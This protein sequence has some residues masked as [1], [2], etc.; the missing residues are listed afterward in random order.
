MQKQISAIISLKDRFSGPLI[1]M[2]SNVEKI[3]NETRSSMNQ[4]N[5]WGLQVEKSVDRALKSTAKWAK[6]GALVTGAW[7]LKSGIEGMTELDDAARKVKSIS[8]HRLPLHGIKED[9]KSMSFEFGKSYEEIGDGFYNAIS[10]SIPMDLLNE[11]VELAN[12]LSIAGFTDI[13]SSVNLMASTMNAFNMKSSEE[14]QNMADQFLLT[15]NLGVITVDEMAEYYGRISTLSAQIG[16]SLEEQNAAIATMT[17]RGMTQ[18]ESVTAYRSVLNAFLKKSSDSQIAVLEGMGLGS[19]FL[20]AKNYEKLGFDGVIDAVGKAT[21]GD[22]DKISEIFPDIRGKL[23][24]IMFSPDAGMDDFRRILKELGDPEGT[25]D[26]AHAVMNQSISRQ[27]EIFKGRV[28]GLNNEL[29]TEKDGIGGLLVEKLRDANDWLDK[30]KDKIIEKMNE[31]SE[32]I[33]KFIEGTANAITNNRTELLFLVGFLTTI[34]ATLKLFRGLGQFS[35]NLNAIK[36]AIDGL[37]LGQLAA[38]IPFALF[39]KVVV[40]ILAIA[41]SIKYIYDNWD[42][43]IEQY[44]YV[45]EIF[46]KIRE[47]FEELSPI[48]FGIG[49]LIGWAFGLFFSAIE[50]TPQMLSEM[51]F[52]IIELVGGAFQTILGIIVTIMGI[53]VLVFT[54]DA[55]IMEIGFSMVTDGMIGAWTGFTDIFSAPVEAVLDLMESKFKDGVDNLKGWWKDFKEFF[56]KPISTTV[57]VFRKV[58]NTDKDRIL[59]DGVITGHVDPGRNYKGTPNWK[60]GPTWIHERGGEIMDLPGGTRIYPHDESVKMARNEG[61]S[62]AGSS[63]QNISINLGGVNFSGDFN[64]EMDINEVGTKI[65][66]VIKKEL[67][68]I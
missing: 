23:G 35:T 55:E 25:L 66:D 39:W 33:V 13:D 48:I 16:S 42:E 28:K 53:I 30:N 10:A 27:W 65:V 32:S 58:F 40:V 20:T 51:F 37:K 43:L 45:E 15:Q 1:K 11:A 46:N 2:S 62:L 36:G 60:G 47:V 14:M 4:V 26:N 44:P 68:N 5:R 34:Y 50:R 29:F 22:L 67:N 41:G 64:T 56:Q 17:M 3:T 12:Q 6:R 9:I 38:K 31:I 52:G 19:D 8:G 24:A 57:T 54:G 21:G 18:R 63:G 49:K 59:E 7:S 61:L